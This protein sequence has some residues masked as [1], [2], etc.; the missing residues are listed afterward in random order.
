M[1]SVSVEDRTKEWNMFA[2]HQTP[3]SLV[4][5]EVV[6]V[7]LTRMSLTKKGLVM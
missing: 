7:A 5:F 2:D 3:V 1:G 6:I 4:Y